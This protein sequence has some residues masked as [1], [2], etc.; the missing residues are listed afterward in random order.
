MSNADVLLSKVRVALSVT[1]VSLATV[2]AVAVKLA[3]LAPAM[4]VTL[5]G[6]VNAVLLLV[7]LTVNVEGAGPVK[8]IVPVAVV[9]PW[10]ADCTNTCFRVGGTSVSVADTWSV[11]TLAFTV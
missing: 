5:A 6:T 4:M 11:P 2:F 7:R 1:A 8:R 10:M 9:P 3:D